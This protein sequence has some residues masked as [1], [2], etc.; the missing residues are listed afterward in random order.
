M[1]SDKGK[2]IIHVS[3]PISDSFFYDFIIK[4]FKLP[5]IDRIQGMA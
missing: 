2:E 3:V 5:R 1:E 4:S